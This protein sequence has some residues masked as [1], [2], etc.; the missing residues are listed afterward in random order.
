MNHSPDVQGV[1]SPPC[2]QCTESQMLGNENLVAV[3][4]L[5]ARHGEL[6][7]PPVVDAAVNGRPSIGSL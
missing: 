4:W 1:L 2:K 7:T 6:R 3:R 5:R